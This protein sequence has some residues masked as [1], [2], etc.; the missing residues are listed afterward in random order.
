MP[1]DRDEPLGVRR[2]LLRG[3][4]PFFMLAALVLGM[5]IW[6]PSRV[7][8][9][10]SGR[11]FGRGHRRR[12][13]DD[14]RRAHQFDGGR[15]GCWCGP[16]RRE[17]GRACRGRGPVHGSRRADS[18][19]PVLARVRTFTGDNGGATSEG[20]TATEIHVA[21][22]RTQDAVA[23]GGHRPDRRAEIVDNREDDRA[24]VARASSTTST[25]ASSSTAARS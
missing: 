17:R 15:D 24:H 12:Q 2:R 23:R 18:R 5:S 16:R 22:R 9:A 8:E 10:R 11:G 14:R 21:M 1:I 13:P 20:V 7:Q 25:S 3:Y 19:R 4:G 6:V